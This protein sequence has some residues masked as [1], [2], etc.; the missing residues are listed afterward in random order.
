MAHSRE[1]ITC[2]H[3]LNLSRNC[4]CKDEPTGSPAKFFDAA[5]TS[6]SQVRVSAPTGARIVGCL[7]HQLVVST[8]I[9]LPVDLFLHRLKASVSA[10]AACCCPPA[11]FPAHLPD[12]LVVSSEDGAITEG[13]ATSFNSRFLHAMVVCTIVSFS[14]ARTLLFRLVDD[15]APEGT[16]H[17]AFTWYFAAI[18]VPVGF[19]AIVGSVLLAKVYLLR[20]ITPEMMNYPNRS[21]LTMGVLDGLYTMLYTLAL[22]HIPN[23]N[24][25]NSLNIILLPLNMIGSRLILARSYSTAHFVGAALAVVACAFS[26][27][28]SEDPNSQKLKHEQIPYV[29]LLLGSYLPCS[30]SW[31]LKER[32][33]KESQTDPW[34]L[35]LWVAIYQLLFTVSAFFWIPTKAETSAGRSYTFPR[36]GEYLRDANMCFFGAV[37]HTDAACETHTSMLW[38]YLG[39]ICLYT[40]SGPDSAQ[41]FLSILAVLQP[42]LAR[43]LA[44]WERGASR[45]GGCGL[46]AV[47]RRLECYPLACGQRAQVRA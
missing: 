37:Q 34:F 30:C 28:F 33:L 43:D 39:Y 40:V 7:H 35:N 9:E 25:K 5:V 47:H 21:L 19:I 41:P 12:G 38:V 17:A 29:I 20:D 26:V 46:R 27:V 16:T 1:D 13:I 24:L 31:I 4:R 18:I 45:H 14:V 23:A 15:Y 8:C 3:D 10:L 22:P 36:Y 42:V 11:A 2:G 32:C 44:E 6:P